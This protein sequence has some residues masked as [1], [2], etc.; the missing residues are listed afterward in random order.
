MG[1]QKVEEGHT[2]GVDDLGQ[3][4]V[5]IDYEVTRSSAN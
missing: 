1:A 4:A 3:F 2:I 5:G